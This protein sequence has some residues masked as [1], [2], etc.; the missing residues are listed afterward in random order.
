M[1][2]D[3]ERYERQDPL[4]RGPWGTLGWGDG[5]SVEKLSNRGQFYSE[6][7]VCEHARCHRGR[8]KDAGGGPRGRRGSL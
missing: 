2:E 5:R 7:A 3:R 1:V 4:V 6:N 8:W